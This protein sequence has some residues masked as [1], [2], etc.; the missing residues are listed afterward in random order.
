MY[1]LSYSIKRVER[2]SF[3]IILKRWYSTTSKKEDGAYICTFTSG[4]EMYSIQSHLNSDG[5]HFFFFFLIVSL[6][7]LK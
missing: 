7:L 6:K 1:V 5:I 2:G 3:T 4:D